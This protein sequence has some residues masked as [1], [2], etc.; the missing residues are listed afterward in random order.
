MNLRYDGTDTVLSIEKPED[1]DYIKIFEENYYREFGFTMKND[2]III[3]S[4]TVVGLGKSP[5]IQKFI[6]NKSPKPPPVIKVHKCYFKP[7]DDE[8]GKFIDTNVYLLSDFGDG[9]KVVGPCIVIDPKYFMNIVVEP[10]CTAQLNKYG[11]LEIHLLKQFKK[12]SEISTDDVV[13]RSLFIHRFMS[14]AEQMGVALQRTSKSVNIKERLDFSCALFSH[15]GG[16]VANAPHLPVHLGAMQFA[17]KFQINSGI[18]WTPNDV[19]LSNHPAAGGSHLPDFTVITP[20]FY[21]GPLEKPIIVDG[22]E[23]DF[24]KPIFFVASRAHHAD[25]GGITPGSMPPFSRLLVE[26]GAATKCLKIT[27]GGQFRTDAVMEFLMAPG[28]IQTPFETQPTGSRKPDDNIADLKAQIAA[29]KRGIDLVKDLI[30]AYSIDEVLSM[31]VAVQRAAEMAVRSK[32]IQIANERIKNNKPIH[33]TDYMDNGLKIKL[34]IHIDPNNGDSVFDFTGTSK[35]TYSNVNS[36]KSVVSS[37]IIYSLRSMVDSDIPL[38]DGCMVPV[39]IIIP[40]GTFLSPSDE[41]A[42]V[43]GNVLTSQRITDIILAAFEAQA[44]SQGCMNNFTFGGKGSP[45]YYE[46]IAGG[47][48]AGPH[49]NGQS[50]IQCHMTN[51]RIT[52][53]EILERRFPVKLLEFSIRTG[54]GGSGKYVGGNGVIRRVQFLKPITVSILSERRVL[55]PNGIC[56]GENGKKGKNLLY[57]NF[58]KNNQKIINIGGKNTVNVDV[59]DVIE[60][61]TPGGGGYG[62]I[63]EEVSESKAKPLPLE[64]PKPATQAVPEVIKLLPIAPKP[65]EYK[66]WILFHP[67]QWQGTTKKHLSIWF[68]TILLSTFVSL[69]FSKVHPFK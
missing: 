50:A 20:V 4:M 57:Q 7:N 17:V 32:L 54:S 45:S 21:D 44:N 6:Y 16:L 12:S 41:A 31:M 51:T 39:K 5:H 1:E 33:Y 43:G 14:I 9:D 19:I 47:A 8:E 26:E 58:G 28:K 61:R 42:V 18:E 22:R 55:A 25:I 30:D 60:I 67:S 40:E 37:A 15:T 52:D 27:E 11:H 46:T 48:G 63:H 2:K 66:G 23:V 62:S 35:E 36:P 10:N 29:N 65:K 69:I 24:K 64:T 53:P 68:S 38:N 13:K 59:G 34:Q 49:W 56:G 3:E